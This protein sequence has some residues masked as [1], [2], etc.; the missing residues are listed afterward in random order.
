MI[1]LPYSS[2]DHRD[3]LRT[4]EPTNPHE[5]LQSAVDTCLHHYAKRWSFQP[6]IED[7]G[8]YMNYVRRQHRVAQSSVDS[9]LCNV[10]TALDKYINTDQHGHRTGTHRQLTIGFDDV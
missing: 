10:E 9:E 4:K 7:K 5:G 3:E 2:T 6:S 8:Q 1:P